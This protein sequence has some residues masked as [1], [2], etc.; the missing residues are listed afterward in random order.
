MSSQEMQFADPEWRPPEEREA[1][2]DPRRQ[3]TPPPQPFNA[4]LREQSQWQTLPPP[5]QGYLGPGYA[6]SQPQMTWG[7]SARPR[8]YRSY[9]R[10]NLWFWVI[11]AFI[12]IALMSGGLSRGFGNRGYGPQTRFSA[13][14]QPLSYN[15]SATPTIMINSGGGGITVETGS[16][17]N[18]VIITP[19]FGDNASGINL[20][21]NGNTITVNEGQGGN[22][23]PG[24]G[25]LDVVVP[26]N[27]NSILEITTIDGSIDVTGVNG[28][29]TLKSTDGDITAN[30]DGLTGSSTLISQSGDVTFSG[31]IGS[32]NY[33]F[34]SNSGAVDV[35]L[36]STSNF[37]VDANASSNS[38][39]Q[40]ISSEFPSVHTQNHPTS[41]EAHGDV[42][43]AS[44]ARVTLQTDTGSISLH[45]S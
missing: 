20:A 37:H 35:T 19:G 29:L 38:D 15:V 40:A 6:G 26:P 39:P 2:A 33:Q 13:Q 8:P 3:E 5:Q 23:G 45:A 32:G 30:N 7:R 34:Q 11:L 22:F 41:S 43:N 9:G 1:T 31:T 14:P 21:Q 36:P 16:A 28:Q 17:N 10:R 25:N 18:Q 4:D 44:A 42:G 12:I 27:F 24:N